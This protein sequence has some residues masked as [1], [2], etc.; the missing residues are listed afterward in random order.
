MNP[1]H[2]KLIA[3]FKSYFYVSPENKTLTPISVEEFA[4]YI[5]T[6]F[7]QIKQATREECVKKCQEL[8]LQE[9]YCTSGCGCKYPNGDGSHEHDCIWRPDTKARQENLLLNDVITK[10]TT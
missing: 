4:K 3:E 5:S 10:L 8:K 7:L 1:L 9:Y 6:A 2:E